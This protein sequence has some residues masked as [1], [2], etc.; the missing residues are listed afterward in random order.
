MPDTISVAL[1]Q[2]PMN[3]SDIFLYH[4]TTNRGIYT[5]HPIPQGCFDVLLYN[6][7][8]EITEF[9][10]GNVVYEIDGKLYT[11]PIS[12]GL[13][14]GTYRAEMLATGQ[15]EE[16]VLMKDELTHINA[17]YFINS[18]REMKRAQF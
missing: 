8:G 13:L 5:A 9:T 14:A 2:T 1:A 16:R 17:L 4:K 12:S 10:F 18:V 6:E 15:V 7:R 11:P 3:S